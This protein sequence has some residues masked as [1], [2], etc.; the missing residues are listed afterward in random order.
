ADLQP[1]PDRYDEHSTTICPYFLAR[2]RNV[3]LG[4]AVD[5]GRN[6]TDISASV[7]RLYR[8]RAPQFNQDRGTGGVRSGSAMRITAGRPIVLRGLR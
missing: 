6:E 8:L 7:E 2:P 1:A 4:E 5:G 3:A